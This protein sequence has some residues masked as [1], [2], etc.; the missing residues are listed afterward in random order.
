MK[1][2]FGIISAMIFLVC[3]HF[4]NGQPV[5]SIPLTNS[6]VEQWVKQHFGKGKIPPFSFIYGGKSSN[7]FI[8]KWQFSAQKLAEKEPN[9]L[10]TQFTWTDKKSGLVVKCNVIVFNDFQAVEWILKFSNTSKRNTP[11]IEKVAVVD[12]SFNAGTKGSFVLHHAKGSDAARVDFQPIDESLVTGKNVYMTPAGGRSSDKTA[13]PF[14]NIEMPGGQGMMVAVGWTGKW[15]ADVVQTNENTVT[16]NSGMEKMNMKLLPGE[17]IRTP[18][19]SLLFWKGDD[20]MVGHNQFRQF[21]LAHHSRKVNGQFAEYPLS[22]SFDY[23]D[24]APCG[25]YECLTEEYAIAL[26]KRYQQFNTLPELFWLDAGWYKGC[27]GLVK[28]GQWHLNVGNWTVEK[29]RFPNGLR[30]VADAVHKTGAKFMVWFEPERVRPETQID[31]EHPEWLIKLPNNKNYLFN[32]GNKE[33]LQWMTNYITDFIKKEGIDYYR[34]DFNFD[35][36]PYWDASDAP[37]RIGIS[38]IRHIEGLY[39]FWDSLLVRFPNLL[40][41]NCASGGRRLDL[42]TTSRSAPLWR[43][44]YQYGEPNGYQCHTFGLNFYVPIHGT[45]IYKTDGY[46][47]RSG[48]GA[49]AVLNWEVTGRNSESIPAIQKRIQDYKNIRPYYYGD[50]YPLT[51]SLNNQT[52]SV[53]LAYQL[54]RPEQNDGIIIAFRRGECPVESITVKIGGLDKNADYE[55]VDDDSGKKTIQ[56]GAELAKGFTLS[57]PEKP[58]SLMFWYKKKEN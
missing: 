56:K 45:A 23:G 33:A 30:P 14:F 5:K 36:K 20:R 35:P 37:D 28:G 19:I 22:G 26:V 43:T 53:W 55:L 9:S 21:I 29:E 38:E 40:I 48:L 50:Y 32:L 57:I 47:F 8:K 54:N 52:D 17:E 11:Q 1:R 46:T 6:E 44:D 49:T 24:P 2:I 18:K 3:C 42:E 16:L 31:R 7:D 25:E 10:E 51:Q 34:Q 39:A 13:F 41:D 12:Q 4:A 27:N 15:Y 58:G